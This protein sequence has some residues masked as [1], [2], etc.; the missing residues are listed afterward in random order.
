MIGRVHFG[1]KIDNESTNITH[2]VEEIT[3]VNDV[4][5]ISLFVQLTKKLNYSIII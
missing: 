1:I 2:Y 4:S 3:N 5:L